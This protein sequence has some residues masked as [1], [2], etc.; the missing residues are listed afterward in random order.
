MRSGDNKLKLTVKGQFLILYFNIYLKIKRFIYISLE[1]EID[2]VKRNKKFRGGEILE[3]LVNYSV[4]YVDKVERV[5]RC[6]S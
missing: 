4:Y 5:G 2:R 1:I 6:W 3:Y